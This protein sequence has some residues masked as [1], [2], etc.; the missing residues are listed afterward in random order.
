MQWHRADRTY[1]DN[2]IL[3][4]SSINSK[5]VDRFSLTL[6]KILKVRVPGTSG[7]RE[8]NEVCR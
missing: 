8:V 3:R 5:E 7:H 4:L 1:N 2:E 6:E